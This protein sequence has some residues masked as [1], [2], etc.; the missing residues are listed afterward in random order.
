M[1]DND[2]QP[3]KVLALLLPEDSERFVSHIV[4]KFGDKVVAVRS[5]KMIVEIMP[6]GVNKGAACKRVADSYGIENSDIICAGDS[7]N[8]ISMIEYAGLGVATSDAMPALKAKADYISNAP[9]GECISDIIDRFCG[10]I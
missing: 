4:G 9:E 10:D 8:D 1:R 7:E 2:V 3:V 6:V 5:H